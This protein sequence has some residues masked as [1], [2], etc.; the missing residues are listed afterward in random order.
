[1][2]PKVG[3]TSM[4]MD[5][6]NRMMRL[7][8]EEV[9]ANLL[10]LSIE[11]TSLEVIKGKIKTDKSTGMPILDSEGNNVSYPDAFKLSY[12]FRG[13]SM[14]QR[15]TEEMFRELEVGSTY[16][17]TGKAGF[18]KEYGQD[19]FAPVFLSWKKVA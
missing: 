17:C 16:K 15:I 18:V 11:V 12:I 19:L 10:V 13:G 9:N 6:F 8:H 4:T 2:S 7:Y 3:E 5:E 14:S 1:M